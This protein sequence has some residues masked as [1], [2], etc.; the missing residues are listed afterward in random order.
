MGDLLLLEWSQLM[1]IVRLEDYNTRMVFLGT[2]TFSSL[3]GMVGTFLLLRKRSLMSDTISHATLPGVGIAFLLL[4]GFTEVGKSLPLLLLGAGIS[5]LLGVGLIQFVRRWSRLKDDVAMAIVLSFFFGVGITLLTLIQQ[6]PTG[7]AAGLEQFIYGKASAM[8]AGDATFIF[9]AALLTTLVCGLFY[10]ELALLCFDRDFAKAKG[11]PTE[12]LDFILLLL[13]TVT[14][15]IG[16]QAIGLLLVVA[17]LIIPAAAARFW[18]H[19]LSKM[20]W[21]A[22]GIGL[23]SGMGGVFLSAAFP[24]LPAGAV[25]V[26]MASLFFLIS[27]VFGTYRGLLLGWLN[28]HRL[29]QRIRLQHLL[30]AIYEWLEKHGQC[31]DILDDEFGIHDI[32]PFRAWDSGILKLSF[33]KALKDGLIETSKNKFRLTGNGA[34]EALKTV[35]HHRLWELFL[36]RYA[37]TAPGR[38][39]RDADAI[40]HVLEPEIIEDLEKALELESHAKRIPTSPHFIETIGRSANG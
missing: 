28:H 34:R 3:G 16:L 4:Y 18:T 25:I 19:D 5:S 11:L 1:R 17:M 37:D 35:R 29:S 36:I 6:L 15:V 33:R 14:T 8:T 40:E 32:R 26:L 27:L 39:D 30:R 2:A 22:M 38:V 21:V 13:I 31:G 23:I 12:L 9:I 10:K 24:R 20:M 7:N